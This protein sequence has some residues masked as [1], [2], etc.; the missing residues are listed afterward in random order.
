MVFLINEKMVSDMGLKS[1]QAAVGARLSYWRKPGKIVGVMKNFNF[2]PLSTQIN[3][4]VL[5][6]NPERVAVMSVRHTPGNITSSLGFIK[7][8]W[9][10]LIPGY[11]FEYRFLN[12]E[13]DRR[14]RGIER[15]GSLLNVFTL[16]AISIACL[17]L[18]GLISFTT[19]QR[20]KEIG[21]RKVF[22][23]PVRSVV[24]LLSKEFTRCVL[25]ANLIAWPV[26]YFAMK[27]WLR[28]FAYKTPVGIGIF[29]L[30][31]IAA[32][33][34]AFLTVSYKS[35]RAARANPVDTL[36]YE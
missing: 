6:L 12:D 23:A 15:I 25:I 36:K 8:T 1:A 34:I 21:I 32:L 33:I 20:S 2:Q 9:E 29:F 5:I 13:F 4:L 24:V 22:G 19:E 35:I 14:Y 28:N 17:G 11:P 26:A 31:G 18:F 7:K 27:S 10:G 30:S 3:P 16:L